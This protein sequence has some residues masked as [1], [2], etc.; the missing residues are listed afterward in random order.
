MSH[1]AAA[2]DARMCQ[3]GWEAGR[4]PLAWLAHYQSLLSAAEGEI[5]G[6]RDMPDALRTLQARHAR[7]GAALAQRIHQQGSVYQVLLD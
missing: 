1:T 4:G 5:A 3:A 6:R 7:G 2:L